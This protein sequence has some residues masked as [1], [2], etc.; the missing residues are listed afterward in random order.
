MERRW[1]ASSPC[2][3]CDGAGT[4]AAAVPHR[5]RH[6]RRRGDGPRSRRRRRRG[7]R[8]RRLRGRDRRQ[9]PRD[10]GGRS[11]PSRE[12]PTRNRRRRSAPRSPATSRPSPAAR[13]LIV[14]DHVSLRVESH[15]MI[16][17]ASRWVGTLGA[18]DRVG[19][20]VLPLPGLN[21]EFTTDHARVREALA[22]VRPLAK[23]PQPFSYRTVSPWEAIRITEGDTFITQQVLARECRGEPA[24]PGE[25]DML[26]RSMKL[27]SEAAVMPFLG[28]LRAAVKA[29]G[30]LPGPKHAVLLSSGWLMTERDAATAIAT[31]AA[32]AAVVERDHPHV[33]LG[34]PGADGLAAAAEPDAGPGSRPAGE[35]RRDGVGHDRRPRGADGLEGRPGLRVAQRGSRRVLPARCS[36]PAGG[37]RR[38]AAQDLGEG[39]TRRREAGRQPPHP[40]RDRVADGEGAGERRRPDGA[41][42]RAREP[43]ARA[44]RR[45][46][47]DV[48]RA[49]RRGRQPR[50]PR[51]RR[52]GRRARRRRQGDG[53]R[54]ALR[55]RGA[56]GERDGERG[57]RAG[58][59][60][61]PRVDRRARAAGAL[62]A[63]PRRARR[64]GARRQPRA[65][66]RR[67]LEDDRPGS[68]RPAWCCSGR[69]SA[70]ARRRGCCSGP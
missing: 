28:S 68:R 19:V 45:S 36:R 9:A 59:R 3:D 7:P 67:A 20:M 32:D 4:D 42:R 46:A 1:P 12:P 25:I 51:R 65:P 63:A 43:D 50:R 49:A 53:G 60:V 57:R 15:G 29:M 48:L 21:I 26:A 70:R 47:G 17:A 56:P 5:R 33:H 31:V 44:R 62:R 14:I 35:H 2:P 18:V 39:A 40:G 6:R 38:Q 22:T 52:R 64:R 13:I 37:S 16:E 66:D 24:C 10:R 61:G 54:R 34:G 8:S 27:D 30:A 23:P 58:E 55:S 41:A 11:G 69:R